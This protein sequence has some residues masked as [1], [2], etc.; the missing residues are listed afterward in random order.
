M[1]ENLSLTIDGPLADIC[2]DRPAKR[3]ALTTEMVTAIA[4]FVGALPADV[5]VILLRGEG[6]AFCGG[7][8][9]RVA[10]ASEEF[11]AG[12]FSMLDSLVSNSRPVVAYAHGPAVGAGMELLLASDIVIMAP[13]AWCELPPARLGFALDNWSIRRLADIVGLG[14][15][16]AIL[17]ASQRVS[18]QRAMDIGLAHHLGDCDTARELC[19]R[20]ASFPP[21]GIAQLKAVLNDGGYT[22]KLSPEH[23]Q[24]FDAAWAAARAPW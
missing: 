21:R 1:K 3:N 7:A 20:I 2:L 10:A 11:H 22:H 19:A 16:R 18:A 24:L 15:A 14:H 9:L 8:D 4:E 6:S 23:Q 13:D 5:R 12:L 17:L